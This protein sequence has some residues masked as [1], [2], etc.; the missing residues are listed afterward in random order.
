M[1]LLV[2]EE[3]PHLRDVLVRG[4]CDLAYAVDATGD[5][6]EALTMAVV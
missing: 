3:Y 1:R 4:R 6:A 2:T 5:G